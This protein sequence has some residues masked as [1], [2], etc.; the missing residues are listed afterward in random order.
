MDRRTEQAWCASR[1]LDYKVKVALQDANNMCDQF[2]ALAC[3][4]LDLVNR[5]GAT[6]DRFE[7]SAR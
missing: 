3:G 4:A 2:R 1:K 7:R 5:N 6:R